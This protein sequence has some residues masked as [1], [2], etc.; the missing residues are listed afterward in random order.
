MVHWYPHEARNRLGQRWRP[1]WQATC[2]DGPGGSSGKGEGAAAMLLG[3]QMLAAVGY[4]LRPYRP[5][6][7]PQHSP[8]SQ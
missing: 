1:G 4:P 2:G 7:T 8:P 6:T 3:G 5:I